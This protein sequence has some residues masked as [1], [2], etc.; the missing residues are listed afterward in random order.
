MPVTTRRTTL[1]ILVAAVI[2][3]TVVV[4]TVGLRGGGDSEAPKAKRPLSTKLSDLDTTRMTIERASFCS[5]VPAADV[6]EALGGKPTDTSSY[7]SGD[8]APL[9]PKVEDIANEHAC[10]WQGPGGASVAAW[11]FAPP[12]TPAMAKQIAADVPKGCRS[13]RTA[14]FGDP[15]SA[16]RCGQTVTVRGLFGDAW[17]SCSL[18]GR[19]KEQPAAI[20]DRAQRW[21]ATVATSAS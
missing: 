9:T 16:V 7:T 3:V 21:C 2:A 14:E 18:T 17:L 10:G 1:G 20:L 12:V 19:A 11:V 6:T 4:I 15:S 13:V 8:K 5:K